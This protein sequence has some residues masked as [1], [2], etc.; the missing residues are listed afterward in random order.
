MT[1]KLIRKYNFSTLDEMH[2]NN[3]II[4]IYH[5]CE[6]GRENFVPMITVWHDDVCQVIPNADP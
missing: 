4:R 2:A 3:Q 5:E 1:K 6:G